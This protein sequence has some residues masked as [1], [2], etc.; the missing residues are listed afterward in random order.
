LSGLDGADKQ[1]LTVAQ[2]GLFK[3]IFRPTTENL[4]IES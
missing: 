2:Q 4:F 3:E 1:H